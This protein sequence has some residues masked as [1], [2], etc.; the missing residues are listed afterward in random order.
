MG[1]RCQ[2]VTRALRH[3]AAI[4]AMVVWKILMDGS[5]SVQGATVVEAMLR[6]C[7][8]EKESRMPQ[9]ELNVRTLVKNS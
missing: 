2:A 8:Q 1:I 9:P 3:L 6:Y 7:A 4:R 5:D